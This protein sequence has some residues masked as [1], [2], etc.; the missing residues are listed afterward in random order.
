MMPLDTHFW[1]IRKD[2]HDALCSIALALLNLFYVAAAVAGAWLMRRRIRYLAL[3]L[4]FPIVRSL[5]LAT[6]GGAED[7]YTLECFPVV[8]VLAAGF[9]TWFQARHERT[10][11]EI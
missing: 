5:F 9:L 11:Q 1:E 7:R 10:E 2:P 6:T 3:L 4:T 8:F